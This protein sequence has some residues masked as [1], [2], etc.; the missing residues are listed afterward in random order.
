MTVNLGKTNNH[1]NT[2][3]MAQSL[4]QANAMPLAS[5]ATAHDVSRTNRVV[6]ATFALALGL[7]LLSVVGYAQATHDV[8]HDARHTFSFPCH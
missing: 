2:N 6:T 8:A 3:A 7:C 1:A 4:K 5:G